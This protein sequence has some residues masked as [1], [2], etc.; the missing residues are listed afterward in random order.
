MEDYRI[1]TS[2]QKYARDNQYIAYKEAVFV[3]FEFRLRD[4]VYLIINREQYA[5]NEDKA[6]PP[7]T[8]LIA[9]GTDE[10]LLLL[11]IISYCAS[12][13]IWRC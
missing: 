12:E 4:S 9:R 7:M 10:Y 8:D 1:K 5:Q 2:R 6:M 11:D 13:R 3:R